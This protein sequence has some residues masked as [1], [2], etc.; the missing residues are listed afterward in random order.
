MPRRA[1]DGIDLNRLHLLVAVLERRAG[2]NLRDKDIFVNVA[3]GVRLAEPAADL[4][5]ALSIAS[6]VRNQPAG[7]DV[8]AIGELGLSGEVRRIAQLERR[9]VEGARLGF[10]RAIVPRQPI[11]RRDEL[12]EIAI[13]PVDTISQAITYL[14]GRVPSG[15]L[16]GAE[17]GR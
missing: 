1:V 9:L 11:A 17:L 13:H 7:K 4:S 3:G 8:V 14:F 2:L 15:E 12:K 10:K 5:V 16:V 6:N